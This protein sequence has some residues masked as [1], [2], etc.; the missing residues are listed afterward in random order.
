MTEARSAAMTSWGRTVTAM[1]RRVALFDRSAPLPITVGPEDGTPGK[2]LP[3]TALA[4]S[5]APT[6]LP[7]GNGRSYGDSCL[8]EGGTAL[9]TTGLDHFI[10]FDPVRGVV[11][12]E[13]G[14]TL[15]AVLEVVTPRG[16][17]LPVVPGTRFA[18]VAGAIA[19]D[20]HGKNH[21]GSGTFG[22]HVERFELVRSD[23]S[24]RICSATDHPALFSATIGGLGLTGLITWAELRLRRITSP[25]LNVEV[26][27][28][29]NLDEFFALTA[30]AD[31]R[32]E[33]S[34]AWVDCLSS[35]ARLGRGVL[36][37]GT[38]ASSGSLDTWRPRGGITI[39]F[40][41]PFS[42]VH[43]RA[44]RWMN[45]AYFHRHRR[46]QGTGIQHFEPF[47]FPLDGVG[48][49]NRLYGRGGMIQYQCV[50]PPCGA[51]DGIRSLLER[52]SNAGIGSFLATLKN[53]GP[54]PSPG[55]LSFPMP[56][57]TLALDFP[58]AAPGL[59][60]LLSGLDDD[61]IAAGGRLYPAKD[62]RMPGWLFRQSYP[63]HEQLAAQR[64]PHFSSSFWRR[65]MSEH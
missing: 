43:P 1:Q 50:I 63:A 42:L 36:F 10:A 16:W 6:L 57:T 29:A 23:G 14:M 46:R 53:F 20:I 51:R 22:C 62:A 49:W 13:G 28:I 55:L 58:A 21:H 7:Y 32:F 61:V 48:H 8:N 38:H 24:R 65:V 44:I 54:M 59:S 60:N 3:R 30:D 52:I 35:G 39:P 27:A 40:A 45:A 4:H 2:G 34:V 64:D 12:C 15:A 41:P 37:L 47:F 19:N 18:T 5:G 25:L 56:G 17:F 26:H 31:G 11:S 9:V 33:H